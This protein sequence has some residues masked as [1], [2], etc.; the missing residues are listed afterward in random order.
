MSV[1]EKRSCIEREHSELS[2]SRQ[3][4]LIGLSRASYYRPV[5][6]TESEENLE[7]MHRIDTLYTRYPFYGSRKIREHLRR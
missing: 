5:V 7:L 1:E 3:C 4:E 2:I 6:Q